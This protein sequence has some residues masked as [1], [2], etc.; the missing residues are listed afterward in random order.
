MRTPVEYVTVFITSEHVVLTGLDGTIAF[1]YAL[2]F[3]LNNSR[4]P[5]PKKD[6]VVLVEEKYENNA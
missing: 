5:P 6:E 1:P 4:E 2:T 3:Y